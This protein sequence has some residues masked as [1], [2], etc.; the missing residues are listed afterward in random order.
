MIAFSF[1]LTLAI[2]WAVRVVGAVA[3]LEKEPA[4]GGLTRLGAAVAIPCYFPARP[5]SRENVF[6][7]NRIHKFGSTD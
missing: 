6:P 1:T 5:R 2:R 3:A 7:A 4:D